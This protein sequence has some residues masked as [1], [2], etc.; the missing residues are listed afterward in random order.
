MN[1]PLPAREVRDSS[2]CMPPCRC[3][4]PSLRRGLS[5]PAGGGC[6]YSTRPCSF[7][8]TVSCDT[9]GNLSRSGL[10]CGQPR[11]WS[12]AECSWSAPRCCCWPPPDDCRAPPP[13]SN[14]FGLSVLAPERRRA[15]SPARPRPSLTPTPAPNPLPTRTH[16]L[17]L[18]P[19]CLIHRRPNPGR[20]ARPYTRAHRRVPLLSNRNRFTGVRHSGQRSGV[21]PTSYPQ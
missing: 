14:H 18:L 16:A 4:W 1:P 3:A 12:S 15:S 9:A 6:F 19:R 8:S 11:P 10:P 5:G 7:C 21:A 17:S 13:E 2:L 20:G